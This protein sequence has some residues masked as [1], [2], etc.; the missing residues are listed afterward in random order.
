MTGDRPASLPIELSSAITR[1]YNAHTV[2][3]ARG[4]FRQITDV[5]SAPD[6]RLVANARLRCD[7][8]W[9]QG[10]RWPSGKAVI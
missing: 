5:S 8:P 6:W 2:R 1:H 4:A 10:G 7:F 9:W 3:T